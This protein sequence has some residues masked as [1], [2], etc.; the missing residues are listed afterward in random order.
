MAALFSVVAGWILGS[1]SGQKQESDTSATNI[2]NVLGTHNTV[3][4]L[5]EAKQDHHSNFIIIEIGL[6]LVIVILVIIIIYV[7]YKKCRK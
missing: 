2:V 7:F 4:N 3:V 5:Y 6:E 1:K